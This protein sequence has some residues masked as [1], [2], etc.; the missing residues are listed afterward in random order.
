MNSAFALAALAAVHLAAP[1]PEAPDVIGAWRVTGDTR[2]GRP[3][4]Q[5]WW[6]L[7]ADGTGRVLSGL[8]V[9]DLT[10]TVEAVEGGYDLVYAPT[11]LILR[12]DCQA[13][14]HPNTSMDPVRRALKIEGDGRMRFC[15][16]GWASEPI[17]RSARCWANL[18]RQDLSTWTG[19]SPTAEDLSAYY[20]GAYDYE[21]LAPSLREAPG[22]RTRWVLDA[23]GTATLTSGES[24]IHARW[25]VTRD[26]D[27]GRPGFE[28]RMEWL[29]L[30]DQVGNGRPDCQGTVLPANLPPYR[31]HVFRMVNGTFNASL[32]TIPQANGQLYT[33][34]PYYRLL[35][36]PPLPLPLPE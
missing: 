7:N 29:T 32:P 14:A 13:L 31:Q 5:E 1:P 30:S 3:S 35:R 11:N 26:I 28:H 16:G 33:T 17:A 19:D 2:P 22:C 10:W 24:V 15:G 23:D 25:R 8:E 36:D 20:V 6:I 34:G 27:S 12:P 9:T 21:P 18:E 4:C